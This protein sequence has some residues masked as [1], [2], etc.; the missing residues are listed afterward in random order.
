MPVDAAEEIVAEAQ[1]KG[2]L[3]G[4]RMSVADDEMHKTRDLPPP[5]TKGAADRRTVPKTV[6]IVRANLLRGGKDPPLR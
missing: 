1:R 3:I 4:V 2:D 6:Q 5:A